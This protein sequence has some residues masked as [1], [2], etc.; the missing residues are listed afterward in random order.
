MLEEHQ[1]TSLRQRLLENLMDYGI[2][3]DERRSQ[4]I[5]DDFREVQRKLAKRTNSRGEKYKNKVQGYLAQPSDIDIS[6]VTPYLVMVEPKS[7]HQSLWA[8]ATSHWS[9]P[10]TNGYGRR[11]RYFVFDRQNN[12]LIGIVGLCDPVIGLGVRDN[13]SIKWTKEQKMKRL[14]NCMTAYI[15]GAIPPYNCILGSKLVALTLMFPKVRKD[16]YHKYKYSSSIISGQN[17]KPYLIYIDTLGAFGKSAIYNRLLNW[18]FIDYTKG[19]SHLHITANGSWELIR[20]VVPEDAFE[21][22]EFGQGPNW[23]MRTLRKALHELGLSEEMLS[24][25]WQRGYYRC[26]LAENWQEYLLGDTNRVVWKSFSQ[27]DLVS[28]WH[29]RWVTPRINSL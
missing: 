28:Y 15:L 27:T 8:Y 11:I 13:E 3:W 10:V 4:V 16:F 24:I 12:K 20:Q 2:M 6:K 17:K 9:I 7:E 22:Y 29:Q 5:V 1:K 21:T 26:P 25:G 14:Y 19:R 23:K 18:E